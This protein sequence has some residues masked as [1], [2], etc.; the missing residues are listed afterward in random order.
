VPFLVL[1]KVISDNTKGLQTLGN[2]LGTHT[3]R[4]KVVT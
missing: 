1:L 4:D 3:L 2:F